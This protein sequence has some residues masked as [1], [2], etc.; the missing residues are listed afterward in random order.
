L[1]WVIAL[2]RSIEVKRPSTISGSPVS[3]LGFGTLQNP[4]IPEGKVYRVH[5]MNVKR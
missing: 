3:W 1:R 4:P 2:L 5:A